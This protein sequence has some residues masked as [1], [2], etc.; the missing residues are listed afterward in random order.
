M[1]NLTKK[2]IFQQGLTRARHKS[3]S[4][5]HLR[6]HLHLQRQITPALSPGGKHNIKW[7][8][9]EFCKGSRPKSKFC[10]HT[11]ITPVEGSVLF[12]Q[13]QRIQSVIGANISSSLST[14]GRKKINWGKKSSLRSRETLSVPAERVGGDDSLKALI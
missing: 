14:G 5:T 10:T 6:H 1:F 12:N 13:K 4:T 3:Q 8:L 9:E 7:R 11:G 2:Y